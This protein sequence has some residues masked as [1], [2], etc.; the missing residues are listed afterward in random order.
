MYF[1]APFQ[2]E[3][4]VLDTFYL[5]NEYALD[6]KKVLINKIVNSEEKLGTDYR[7][8]AFMN[9]PTR[10]YNYFDNLIPNKPHSFSSDISPTYSLL[11]EKHL[12]DIKKNFK[13]KGIYTKVIFNIRE[14]IT[15]LNSAIKMM[16]RRK[17]SGLYNIYTE[18]TKDSIITELAKGKIASARVNYMQ[19]HKNITNV[20]DKHEYMVNL[21]E[22][23]FSEIS[24]KNLSYFLFNGRK[25]NIENTKV[26]S[27]KNFAFNSPYKINTIE[28]L[29]DFYREQY[30][31]C[32]SLFPGSKTLWQ[33]NATSLLI[34]N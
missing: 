33:Q 30:E 28:S 20:F 17:N 6:F 22:T 8:L 26:N 25:K 29:L 18:L 15:R 2:K 23:M 9:D 13:K 3:L 19:I 7:L 11:S 16:R 5:K 24:L 21:Y 4:H 1:C 32:E 34:K 10:Y 31:F 12:N 27:S 14:P